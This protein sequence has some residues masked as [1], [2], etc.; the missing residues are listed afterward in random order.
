VFMPG[1]HPH[2]L[3]ANVQVIGGQMELETRH[4]ALSSLFSITE[5]QILYLLSRNPYQGNNL[6]GSLEIWE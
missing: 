1:G 2:P 3:G 4:A 5:L 6:S